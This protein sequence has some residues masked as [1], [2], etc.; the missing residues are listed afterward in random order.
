MPKTLV[1][2]PGLL[3]DARIWRPL[4][5]VLSEFEIYRA[6]V[7]LDPT[8]EAMAERILRETK[9]PCI[10]VG[11]SM[12]GR[13]A[14]EVARQAPDRVKRLVLANT[15][16]H[17]L[18]P[19]EPEKRQ[20]KIDQGHA[21]FAGMIKDWLPPMMAASRHEDAALIENLTD[22]AMAVGPDVHERQI[23]A[24]VA[25]PDASRYLADIE[26]PI[27]L[28]AGTEDVWSPAAQHQEIAE[29]TKDATLHIVENAGHFLPVEQPDETTRLIADW[30]RYQGD[31]Q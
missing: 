9:G 1:L 20:D 21:D 12:G 22:M 25:R 16:H 6:D 8:I 28:L 4:E 2:I 17:P 26:C 13:V 23:K 7:T 11:H 5:S 19:G 10:A 29:L 18:K 14:M 3:S 27:L 24:L 30:L 31:V 15:G